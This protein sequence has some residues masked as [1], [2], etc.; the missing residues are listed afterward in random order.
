M[1]N[2]QNELQ[3]EITHRRKP[4][5][6]DIKLNLIKELIEFEEH[7][8]DIRSETWKECK[9]FDVDKAREELIDVW[10]FYLQLINFKN[11]M[12]GPT[13]IFEKY[14]MNLVEE[15]FRDG[16]E[17]IGYGYK[18]NMEYLIR[19]IYTCE[20]DYIPYEAAECIGNLFRQLGCDMDMFKDMFYK[21]LDKNFK[22]ARKQL[23]STWTATEGDVGRGVTS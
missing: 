21:K 22:R 4:L 16:M 3:K 17:S 5:E 9:L 11:E 14:T 23:Q 1:L 7:L 18:M 19:D 10:F 2:K 13:K 8:G 15:S 12:E 6:D 20:H